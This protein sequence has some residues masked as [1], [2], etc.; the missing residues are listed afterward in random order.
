MRNILAGGVV[1]LSNAPLTTVTA[2]KPEPRRR[3]KRIVARSVRAG[4]CIANIQPGQL[5][6]PRLT[7]GF[8]SLARH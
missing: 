7:C 4:K 3:L 5:A 6:S 2:R 8:P 1:S